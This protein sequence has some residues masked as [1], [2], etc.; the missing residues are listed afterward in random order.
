MRDRPPPFSPGVIG[1]NT[2]VATTISSRLEVLGEQPAGGHFAGSPGVGVGGVEEGDAT[3]DRGP[4]DGF[5]LV[6]VQYPRPIAVVAVAHH[7]EA[8]PRDPQAGLPEIHVVHG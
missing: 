4:D 6:L 8:H 5:G 1:M 2:L 7:P 3:L